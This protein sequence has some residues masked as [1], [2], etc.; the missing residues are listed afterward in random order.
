MQ[1][2]Y[3]AE[4]LQFDLEERRVAT[5]LAER[6][7]TITEH[8]TAADLQTRYLTLSDG[9]LAGQVLGLFGI[10]QAVVG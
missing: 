10:V 4:P 8:L 2:M 5:F 7:F 3:T 9:T 1:A 6:G